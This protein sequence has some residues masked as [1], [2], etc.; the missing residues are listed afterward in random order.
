MC[1]TLR[2]TGSSVLNLHGPKGCMDIYEATKSFV[3]FENFDVKDFT[4]D[5]DVY[6]DHAIRVT[7]VNLESSLEP[8]VAP[9]PL[10]ST[11]EPG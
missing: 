11:W 9:E 1:L 6:E 10:Y 5:D 7:H 8:K 2:Q 4:K 3:T